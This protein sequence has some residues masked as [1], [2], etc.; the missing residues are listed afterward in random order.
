[1][2]RR[3]LWVIAIVAMGLLG[4]SCNVTR[5][6]PKESYLLQRVKVEDD[7]SVPRKERIDAAEVNKYI[8]QKPN[9]HFLGTN[10]YV[11]VYNLANPEKDNWWN[12]FKRKI[13]EEPVLFDEAATEKSA[14]NLKIYLNSRGYF[15][16]DVK[17]AVDTLSRRRRAKVTYS[18]TQNK[19]Y[20]ISDI[21]YLYRDRFLEPILA[22]DTVNSLLHR[23][24][25]FDITVLDKE[26][27][28][29]TKYLRERGYYG[30]SVNNIE[31][32]ADTLHQ[33]NRVGLKVVIKQNLVGYNNR[34][35]AIYDNNVVYRLRRIN[36]IPDYNAADAKS[37][38][39]YYEHFD[40][41]D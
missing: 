22:P 23:G 12:R 16:S 37:H 33:P 30:F 4:S 36:I 38:N 2:R 34:G 20:R 14:E 11:W 6:L 10:F 17:F 25:I 21:S 31:Y 18:L 28:R 27:E 1:M 35:N 15:A 9:K 29:I 5:K 39:G 8:R 13:G 19:A 32:M 26:R 7:K 41:L 40:S 3:I 24:D